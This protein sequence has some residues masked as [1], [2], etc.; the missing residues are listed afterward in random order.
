MAKGMNSLGGGKSNPAE[1]WNLENPAGELN[2]CK[3][4]L[5]ECGR[6]IAYDCDC[7]GRVQKFGS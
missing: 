1:T 7:C 5:L 2:S 6:G 3:C 4:N